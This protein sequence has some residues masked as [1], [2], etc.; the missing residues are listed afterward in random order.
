MTK[1]PC[2][3]GSK[4]E[5]FLTNSHSTEC[6]IR[7]YRIQAFECPTAMN[8]LQN[9]PRRGIEP[10]AQGNTLGDKGNITGCAQTGQKR[11]IL[12]GN[13]YAPPERNHHT[14]YN[15]QSAAPG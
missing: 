9:A 3:W 13:A 2:F 11:F 14:A 8:G 4:L 10:I 15:T 5:V 7:V 6:T 12:E 1:T